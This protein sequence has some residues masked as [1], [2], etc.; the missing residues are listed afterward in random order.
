MQADPATSLLLLAGVLLFGML[1]LGVYVAG[2]AQRGVLTDRSALGEPEPLAARLLASLDRRFRGTALG[3][4]LGHALA[5]AGVRMSVLSYV[6]LCALAFLGAYVLV[7]LVLPGLV[8][9]IFGLTAVAGCFAWVG[10]RRN[11]RRFDF[12]GQL[13]ELARLL[14]NGAQAG[15]SLA[16]A[17]E[18][19]TR[20]LDEPAGEEL[21]LVVAQLRL[22]RSLDEALGALSERLPSR[23]VAVLMSTLV[24]QQRAG[25]DTVRALQDMA[26]T[27]DA[28]KDTLREVRTLMSGAI[29]TSYLVTVMGLGT[30]LLMN[31]VSPG[32]LT[33]M[34]SSLIGLAALAVAGG[35]YA[36]GFVL[37]RQTTR[38]EV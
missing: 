23:E 30:L 38:I 29:F 8:A 14:S 5:T 9:V 36:I 33:E 31:A 34:T 26:E 21:S 19:A 17:L 27:L 32:V 10:R 35:L 1:G 22:G 37:I 28:R 7:S 2:S 24:I 6:G 11:R 16:G 13:P 4:K 18:R 20:E 25:G 15:L 12:V 3:L